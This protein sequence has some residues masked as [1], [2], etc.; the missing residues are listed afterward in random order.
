MRFSART[1]RGAQ[2]AR[3]RALEAHRRWML[4]SRARV[5]RVAPVA[6]ER[7]RMLPPELAAQ[8][9]CPRVL[10]ARLIASARSA[11]VSTAFAAT[12]GAGDNARPA[13]KLAAL[14]HARRSRR[15]I[16]VAL[17][18]LAPA[19][20][21]ARGSVMF[22]VRRPA[23]CQATPRYVWPRAAQAVNIRL[24]R[25]ATAVAL[26]PARQHRRARP[27][28]A[29][30]TVAE[31]ASGPVPP[32]PAPPANTVPLRV[33]AR[34]RRGTEPETRA[35]RGPSAHRLT[36]HRPT[37]F[38][39][40]RTARDSARLVTTARERAR[41]SP[42]GNPWEVVQRA[43]AQPTP[44]AAGVATTRLTVAISR[45]QELHAWRRLARIRRRTSS[46]RPAPGAVVLALVP[47]LLRRRVHTAVATEHVPHALPTVPTSAGESTMDAG[48]PARAAA[49]RERPATREPAAHLPLSLPL[50]AL[51][52]AVTRPT[53]MDAA[54]R[55]RVAP[56][57]RDKSATAAV[58]VPVRGTD[59]G[60][61]NRA[62]RHPGR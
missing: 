12:A 10:F 57:R 52:I 23:R 9:P 11:S 5:E 7:I 58:F 17:V 47:T 22:P 37:V 3:A 51:A 49:V 43:Q 19:R 40:I 8:R 31:S 14:E 26:A 41:E 53:E 6:R 4:L 61:S 1:E 15:A 50:V 13:P 44:L 38:A 25:S 34:R 28:R 56:V 60:I 48:A 59:R 2:V 54:A 35:R 62:K 21:S 18:R 39:A 29:P 27:V 16:P 42:R 33:A 30:P 55:F 46:P 36:A 45:P 32:L 24:N 20:A